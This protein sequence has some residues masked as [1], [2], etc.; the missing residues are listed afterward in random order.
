M[1]SIR[2]SEDEY[3]A[4]QALVAALGVPI[5]DVAREALHDF[6]QANRKQVVSIAH[7]Q[8]ERQI[9]GL[10]QEMK[11]LWDQVEN[12]VHRSDTAATEHE[13]GA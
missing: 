7:G 13:A 3:R 5:S 6:V 10:R 4:L 8:T 1:L 2:L 9:Q 11:R 12:L